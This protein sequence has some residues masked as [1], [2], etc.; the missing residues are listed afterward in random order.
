[1]VGI[2][3]LMYVVKEGLIKFVYKYTTQRWKHSL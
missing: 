3:G 1:M 2:I